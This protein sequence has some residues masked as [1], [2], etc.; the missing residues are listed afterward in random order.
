M[1][2]GDFFLQCV[3]QAYKDVFSMVE[4]NTL[5]EYTVHSLKS[6]LYGEMKEGR[7][8]LGRC[9][10]Q[11]YV[12]FAKLQEVLTDLITLW[13]SIRPYIRCTGN[14]EAK[15]CHLSFGFSW[16]FSWLVLDVV[17]CLILL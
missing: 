17:Y 15:E 8:V 5:V 14:P 12:N 16:N 11:S 3:R 2:G 6:A 1:F 10:R 9:V 4:V 13:P 7:T